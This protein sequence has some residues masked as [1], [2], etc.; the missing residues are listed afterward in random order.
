MSA[1][2]H[3][4]NDDDKDSADG[5]SFEEPCYDGDICADSW[6]HQITISER[7]RNNEKVSFFEAHLLVETGSEGPAART[8]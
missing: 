1:D 4:R 3:L 6:P 5:G 8:S 7:F 2:V